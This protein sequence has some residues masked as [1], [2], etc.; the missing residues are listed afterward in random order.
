MRTN[1]FISILAVAA[2]MF[3]GCEKIDT[4]RVTGVEV[5]PRLALLIGEKRTPDMIVLPVDAS[6]REVSWSSGNPLVAT[7]DEKTGEV[8]AIGE[9][10]AII[11][12]TTAEGGKTAN[13]KVTVSDDILM[14][15]SDPA[16]LEYCQYA[17]THEQETYE[18]GYRVYPAWDRD[19]NGKLSAVEA[20]Q[21]KYIEIRYWSYG[22]V[23]SLSEIWYFSG[24]THLICYDHGLTSLDLSQCPELTY[25]NCS[26]NSIAS[27][28]VSNN[29]S[30][31]FLYCGYNQLTSIDI[32]KNTRLLEFYCAYNPGDGISKFPVKA[33][34]DNNSIPNGYYFQTGGWYDFYND[35]YIYV[36][37]QKVN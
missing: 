28:D 3:V 12:V 24:L 20:A 23:S 30:L 26:S 1:L 4:G 21:V 13:C 31:Q 2:G 9:G 29:K 8:T 5:T 32:S 25:L 27:L 6:N 11:T 22:P 36:D 14:I 33:F 18:D 34:F 17:M 10:T 35:I 15:I 7:V 16:F 37:Y 19:G